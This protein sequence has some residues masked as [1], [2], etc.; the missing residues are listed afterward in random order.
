MKLAD[1]SAAPFVPAT[2][3]LER[4]REASK[5][6][7]GCPLYKFATQTVFGEGPANARIVMFGEQPG[8]SED[9]AGH[10]FIGPA[11]RLLDK[12][13]ADA[14]LQRSEVYISN[15]VKHFKFRTKG[16]LRFHQKP[17][18]S[19]IEACRPWMQKEIEIL[20]PDVT[21]CLGVS[22]AQGLLEHGVTLR[23]VRGK[24]MESPL[25]GALLLTVHPS[26]ILR[27]PD[28]TERHAEF[29]HFVRDLKKVKL[30]VG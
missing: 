25:G 30:W 10:P 2:R 16:R 29:A 27:I 12:A 14:G 23:E 24:S 5:A 20:Q 15:I 18:R 11:G 8:D 28:E 9:K 19:E 6:C 17:A 7:R 1:Y 13:L 4:V 26:S 21:V 22:A 3:S